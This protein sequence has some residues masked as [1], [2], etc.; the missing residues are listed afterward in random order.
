MYLYFFSC[1]HNP[2]VLLIINDITMY[3]HIGIMKCKNME[4]RKHDICV[5]IAI[6]GHNFLRTTNLYVIMLS[7]TLRL[8]CCMSFA[9][10]VQK[11]FHS[12]FTMGVRKYLFPTVVDIMFFCFYFVYVQRIAKN[13]FPSYICDQLVRPAI[14]F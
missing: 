10:I 9:T 12:F 7:N 4:Q 3:L 6:S 8:V 11:F 1:S 13:V 14:Y 2:L 5:C